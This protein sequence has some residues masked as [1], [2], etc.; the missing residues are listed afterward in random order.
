MYLPTCLSYFSLM[1]SLVKPL[2]AHLSATHDSEQNGY[3]H[4]CMPGTNAQAL[5]TK[6]RLGTMPAHKSP[7]TGKMIIDRLN[8]YVLRSF[9]PS[10]FRG[11][12]NLL[13][14]SWNQAETELLN[15][16]KWRGGSS[17][18]MGGEQPI[19]HASCL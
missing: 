6:P 19:P 15:E 12:G 11:K 17:K 7:L 13:K 8:S 16:F 10:K 9:C 3:L 4:L 5:A 2:K 1:L 14:S 18:S